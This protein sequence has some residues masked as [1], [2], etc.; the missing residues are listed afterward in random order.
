M[1]TV[2]PLVWMI[3]G[4]KSYSTS[5]PGMKREPDDC[6]EVL[7]KF[8]I[9]SKGEGFKAL[10]TFNIDDIFACVVDT[11]VEGGIAIGIDTRNSVVCTIVPDS[12]VFLKE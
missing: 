5:K 3:E 9:I 8:R 4:M 2:S 10:T 7:A 11:S 12:L 6:S 1:N